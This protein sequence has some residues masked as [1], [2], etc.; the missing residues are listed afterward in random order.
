MLAEHLYQLG[1][2]K[3][4][5]ISTPFNQLTLAREQRLEGIRKQLELH[6]VT[7]G[8][9]CW[10]PTARPRQTARMTAWPY[11]YSV[12]RQLTAEADPA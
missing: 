12:G 4:V 8:L 6:G 2:R 3:L 10:W 7:D 11:E 1:H 5:F 9:E